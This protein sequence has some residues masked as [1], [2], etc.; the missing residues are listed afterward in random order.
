[1]S[2][3]ADMTK[4]ELLAANQELMEKRATAMAVIEG[5]QIALN[6]ALSV[7]IAEE[8]LIGDVADMSEAERAILADLLQK[9]PLPEPATEEEVLTEDD[10][11]TVTV[12]E[13]T[14]NG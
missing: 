9:V 3:F 12:E 11:A 6:E 14:D 13:V 7:K 5:E 1:M 2:D 10:V 4:D 8:R